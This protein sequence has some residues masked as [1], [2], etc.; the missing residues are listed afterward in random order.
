MAMDIF[1]V[2]ENFKE[3]KFVQL[4]HCFQP[5]NKTEKAFSPTLPELLL[6]MTIIDLTD[7]N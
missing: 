3:L 6:K 2:T 7:I 4:G 1:D 5:T